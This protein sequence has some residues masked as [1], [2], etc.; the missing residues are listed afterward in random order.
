VPALPDDWASSAPSNWPTCWGAPGFHRD[1][2][3]MV[4]MVSCRGCGAW[5]MRITRTR[6]SLRRWQGSQGMGLW[7]PGDYQVTTRWLPVVTGLGWLS[8]DFGVPGTFKDQWVANF[9]AEWLSGTR[10]SG[11]AHGPWVS[12]KR[13]TAVLIFFAKHMALWTL[14]IQRM[15]VLAPKGLLCWCVRCNKAPTARLS[16]LS[17]WMWHRRL[18][19]RWSQPLA[20]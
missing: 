18:E 3:M 2:E 14:V 17:S 1:A 4:G 16:L 10:C 12:G 9:G 8:P 20:Q 15:H 5:T 7:L 13:P 11:A 6:A 19:K